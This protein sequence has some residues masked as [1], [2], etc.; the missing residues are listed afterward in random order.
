M[1][2][3]AWWAALSSRDRFALRYSCRRRR[4]VARYFTKVEAALA[5]LVRRLG[6]LLAT[7][8]SLGDG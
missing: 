1:A 7:N 2:R 4:T 6:S 5:D 8:S 3:Q